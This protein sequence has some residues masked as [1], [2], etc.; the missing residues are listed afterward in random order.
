MEAFGITAENEGFSQH[1]H[2]VGSVCPFSTGTANAGSWES[3]MESSSFSLLRTQYL[4]MLMLACFNETDLQQLQIKRN[5]M[6]LLLAL[7]FSLGVPFRHPLI[8][9]WILRLKMKTLRQHIMAFF[10]GKRNVSFHWVDGASLTWASWRKPVSVL[11][12]LLS[13]CF[14]FRSFVEAVVIIPKSHKVHYVI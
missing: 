9:F 10:G 11:K 5:G 8:E 2:L 6:H 14:T 3:K 4:L 13:H 12:N 1:R 7:N